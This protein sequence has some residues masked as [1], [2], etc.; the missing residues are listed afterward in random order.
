MQDFEKLGLFYLGKEYNVEQSRLLEDLVLYDS[1]DLVTHAVCIGMTGS[2]KTGLCI[3]LIEEAAIDGIPAILIDPKGDLTNL[4]LTFPALSEAD[5]LPWIQEEEARKKGVTPQAYAQSQAEKWNQGLQQWGQDGS[6]IQHLKDAAEY[7]IYT[8][9][10]SAG[11]PLSVLSSFSVP[12]AAVLNDPELLNEAIQG[13]VSS[14]LSIAG[15]DYDPIESR[16]YILLSAVLR[17]AWQSNIDLD[18]P[19]FILKLQKPPFERIGVIDLESF[20]PAKDRFSLSLRL[21]NLLA[22]PGFDLWMKGD[23]FDI[24]QMLYRKD[25][26]PKISILSIAHL[27]D[28]ERMFFV[29][30]LLNRILNWMRKEPGTTSLRAILYMDE[31]FGFFPPVANPPSKAPLLTLLKQARAFGLGVV[32]ST[33]NPVDLDYKGLSN[34]GTWFIGRLQTQRDKDRVLEGLQSVADAQSAK[35]DISSLDRLLSSLG[36]RVFL[37]NNVHEDHPIVFQTRWALSYLS[38]PLTREQIRRLM[39]NRIP[40]STTDDNTTHK[41]LATPPVHPTLGATT[42]SIRPIISPE[43]NQF[44]LPIRTSQPPSSQV[45]YMPHLYSSSSVFVADRKIG[46]THTAKVSHISPLKDEFLSSS[47]DNAESI[48]FIPSDF[49]REGVDA[50][51]Y[52]DL[53]QPCCQP[54]FYASAA[55]SYQDYLYRTFTVELLRSPS[56]GC[57]A[58]VGESEKDFRLRL[59]Q[60]FREQRDRMVEDLRKKYATK[61]TTLEEKIRRAEQ[62]LLKEEEQSRQQKMQTAVSIGTSFLGALLGRRKVSLTSLG[63]AS[64]AMRS[65]GR[66]VKESQDITRAQENLTV[67]GEQLQQLEQALNEEISQFDNQA[68]PMEETFEVVPIRPKKTDIKVELAAL[69]WIPFWV[70]PHGVVMSPAQ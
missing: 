27:N 4:L 8:P 67:L 57:C 19:N 61:K 50:A 13:A 26:K 28:S 20:Y 39:E 33:Q 70:D 1:K 6:R 42:G 5:F 63:K 36:N 65:V 25:G 31:I 59:Q 21:N 15:I 7:C 49:D 38:G 40:S 34:A 58:Q 66:S 22:S 30:L 18:L 60:S 24:D 44:Y 17:N 62:V 69:L 2:G 3:S 53:L 55:K 35:I 11:I 54:R 51:L 68:N 46:L 43:V 23:P 32:L 52:Q 48:D 41:D 9:G 14:L 10:S 12:P 45:F 16:E 29:T 56:Q 47:W 37:L 64:T